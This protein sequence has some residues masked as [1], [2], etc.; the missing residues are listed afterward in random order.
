MIKCKDCAR[1]PAPG[2]RRCKRC[3]KVHNQRETARR[4]ARR[5]AGLCLVCGADAATDEADHVLTLCQKHRQHYV[6]RDA[7]RRLALKET[8]P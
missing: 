7:A 2:K 4:E 3:A 5:V 1:P 8:P 6:E